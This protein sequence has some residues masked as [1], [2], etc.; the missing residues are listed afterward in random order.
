[1]IHFTR[2][3]A[4]TPAKSLINGLTLE[5]NPD[6]PLYS[7][8]IQ[9]HQAYLQALQQSGLSVTT[10]PASEDFPDS[11]FIEDIAVL[12][13][14]F[15]II[16]RPGAESRREEISTSPN[17]LADYYHDDHVHTLS[18]PA[19]LEGGDVMLIDQ[20]FYIGL[21]SRTNQAGIDQFT[22]VAQRYGYAVK[23]IT[24]AY[25]LHLKTGVTY[26]GDNRLVMVKAYETEPHFA[27]FEKIIT[28]DAEKNCANII[29]I[30]DHV[31]LPRGYPVT[32]SMIEGLGYNTINVGISEFAKIDG[33]LTCLSLR[34]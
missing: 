33:G 2:A 9:Q 7:L 20:C 1:M 14:T 23:T 27:D 8:A 34:F 19:L 16:T 5:D 3:L 29:R 24:A 18:A 11:C 4:K 6:K 21:S 12:A 17:L 25:S 15:A 28:P 22:A 26:L 13:P 10:L 30:N 31:I 32:Q